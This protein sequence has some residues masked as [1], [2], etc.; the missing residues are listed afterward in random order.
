MRARAPNA[1]TNEI[2]HAIPLNQ[3]DVMTVPVVKLSSVTF[4]ARH[5][6]VPMLL[7]SALCV[8]GAVMISRRRDVR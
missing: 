7:A 2:S 6:D 8:I 4:Y 5:G 3:T 1:C